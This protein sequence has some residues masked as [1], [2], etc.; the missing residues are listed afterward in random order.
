VVGVG[1]RRALDAQRHLRRR[2][3][4]GIEAGAA[5]RARGGRRRRRWGRRRMDGRAWSRVYMCAA[6]SRWKP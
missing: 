6:A 2:S 1:P 4:C 3:H 5:L